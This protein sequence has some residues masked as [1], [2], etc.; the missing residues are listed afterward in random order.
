MVTNDLCALCGGF[1]DLCGFDFMIGFNTVCEDCIGQYTPELLA[2]WPWETRI[3]KAEP[4]Y[5]AM[6]EHCGDRPVFPWTEY[7]QMLMALENLKTYAAL[8]P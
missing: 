8:P 3:V 7:A 1:S 4:E 2:K 5:N 6:L